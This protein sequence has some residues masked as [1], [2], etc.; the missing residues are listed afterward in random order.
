MPR[1]R[2][3]GAA[4]AARPSH[5]RLLW[6]LRATNL[7]FYLAFGTAT[8]GVLSYLALQ[9][10]KVVTYGLGYKTLAQQI[11][12]GTAQPYVFM[13]LYLSVFLIL[14]CFSVWFLVLLLVFSGLAVATR[15]FI[16]FLLGGCIA[17]MVLGVVWVKMVGLLLLLA[18]VYL[19]LRRS[20]RKD[21]LAK[22]AVGQ[23]LR[24]E[25]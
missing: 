22:S 3:A 6:I 17:A 13:L 9:L 5:P 11:D 21:P 8:L 19:V 23:E 15:V 7:G 12:S 4:G 24:E 2:V 16:L 10:L 1:R 20:W 25:R 18:V 14:L